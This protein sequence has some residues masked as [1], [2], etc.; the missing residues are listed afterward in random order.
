MDEVQSLRDRYRYALEQRAG[1]E[2]E[3]RA[4]REALRRMVEHT[5]TDTLTYEQVRELARA[6]LIAYDAA[7]EEGPD[8]GGSLVV[9]LPGQ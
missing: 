3:A 6:A 4:L 7:Q 5:P 1:V 8:D 2:R 9:E